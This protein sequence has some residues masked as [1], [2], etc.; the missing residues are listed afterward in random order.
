MKN[1]FLPRPFYVLERVTV[2]QFLLDKLDSSTIVS[3]NSYS[4]YLLREGTTDKSN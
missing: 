1:F 4:I 3:R 2:P